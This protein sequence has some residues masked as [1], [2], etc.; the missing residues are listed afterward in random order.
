MTGRTFLTAAA[1]LTYVG[2]RVL[3][4]GWHAIH[5]VSMP[6]DSACCVVL[7]CAYQVQQQYIVSG[8]LFMRNDIASSNIMRRDNDRG[9]PVNLVFAHHSRPVAA[10]Q[11]VKPESSQCSQF[12][13]GCGCIMHCAQEHTTCIC[14]TNKNLWR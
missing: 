10:A 5:P 7:R 9:V 4:T 3:S 8:I 6:R 14:N 2:R 12:T 1:P 11:P 13:P